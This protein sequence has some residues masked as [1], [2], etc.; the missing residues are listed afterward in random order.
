MPQFAQSFRTTYPLGVH[1]TYIRAKGPLRFTRSRTCLMEIAVLVLLPLAGSTL[2]AQVSAARAAQQLPIPAWQRA[3]GRHMA[4]ETASIH[5]AKPGTFMPP[6][7]SFNIDDTSIPPGGRFFADFPLDEYIEFA[8]KIMLTPEQQDAMLAGLPKWVR[9]DHFVIQAEAPGNPTKDQMRLMVQ[10]LLADRFN[11][12]VHFEAPIEPVLA[13]VTVKRGKLGPRIRPHSQGLPCDAKWTPPTDRTSP[14]VPPGGF[15]P[16]CGFIEAIPGP[17]H[18]VMLGARNVTLEQIADY[19]A[20]LLHLG[21][22]VVDR[23]GLSDRFDFTLQWVPERNGA[24]AS[25]A[26]A[27]P[28]TTGP[29]LMEALREECGMKLRSTK[30]RFKPLW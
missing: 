19:L 12:K 7:I 4:F 27:Q 1:S 10:T 18:T 24:S 5:L 21:R 26:S 13:L 23:T 15:M 30:A 6:N 11:L 25:V 28:D 20:V 3:A 17:H 2:V 29:D 9:T 8:Y 16:E 14:T 22:P